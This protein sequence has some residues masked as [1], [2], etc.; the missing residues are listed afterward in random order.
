MQPTN[1]V[2]FWLIV[3]GKFV[4][5]TTQYDRNRSRAGENASLRNKIGIWTTCA[6]AALSVLVLISWSMTDRTNVATN[7]NRSAATTTG[8]GSVT[9][10]D[11]TPLQPAKPLLNPGAPGAPATNR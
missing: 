7:T 10:G 3:E 1:I 9:T 6:F 4:L 5:M 11:S 8:S 2:C